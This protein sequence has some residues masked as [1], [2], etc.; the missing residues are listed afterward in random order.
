MTFLEVSY[1]RYAPQVCLLHY[2]HSSALPSLNAGKVGHG[3]F[4]CTCHSIE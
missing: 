1:A 2:D 3:C 4:G